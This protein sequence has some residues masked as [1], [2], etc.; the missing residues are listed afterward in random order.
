MANYT[1]SHN[2][3]LQRLPDESVKAYEAFAIYRDMG[4]GRSLEAVAQ[5]LNKS[6]T[7]MG[8]WSGQYD[9]VNRAGAYDDYIEAQARKKLE[10]DAIR[11]KADMLKRHAE[12]GRFMQSKG[13]EYLKQGNSLDKA[14]DAIGAIKSGVEMERKSE[15]LPEYLIEVMSASDDD[16]QRRYNELLAQIGGVGS[17]DDAPGDTD[18]GDSNPEQ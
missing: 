16:L 7:L 15:G 11:R 8:R 12:I 1:H 10:R 4:V 13:V 18:T 14:S 3:V 6:V 5:K 9:W 2:G 17:G